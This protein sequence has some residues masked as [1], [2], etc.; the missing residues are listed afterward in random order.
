MVLFLLQA[1]KSYNLKFLIAL[2]CMLVCIG[3]F[4]QNQDCNL[5]LKGRVLDDSTHAP[6]EDVS[7]AIMQ[8]QTGNVTDSSGRFRIAGLCKGQ[9]TVSLT[10]VGGQTSTININ[11]KNDTSLVLVIHREGF[12]L[13]TVEVISEAPERA[14]SIA[15]IIQSEITGIQLLET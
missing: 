5:I 7:V 9:C 1:I 11:L 12:E 2:G 4:G 3:V 15:T 10:L 13:A 8:T 14:N 6:V